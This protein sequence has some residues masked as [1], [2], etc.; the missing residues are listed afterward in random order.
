MSL[1]VCVSARSLTSD[2]TFI[3]TQLHF[4]GLHLTVCLSALFNVHLYVCN[5]ARVWLCLC[6]FATVREHAL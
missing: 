2:V 4:L 6:V 1:D 3:I 5:C